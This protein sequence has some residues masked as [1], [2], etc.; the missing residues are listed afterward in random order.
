MRAVPFIVFMLLIG[1]LSATSMLCFE[2]QNVKIDKVCE[3]LED[4]FAIDIDK[5]AVSDVRILNDEC[6]FVLR[7][8][9]VDGGLK[10][11]GYFKNGELYWV[12]TYFNGDSLILRTDEIKSINNIEGF[13]RY[14][15][16]FIRR[17]KEFFNASPIF[18]DETVRAIDKLKVLND[19]QTIVEDNVLVEVYVSNLSVSIY[20]RLLVGNV[21]TPRLFGLWLPNPSRLFESGGNWA[22]IGF[23]DK[24]KFTKI[25]SYKIV[26][27]EE[28]AVNSTI[29]LMREYFS[30]HPEELCGRNLEDLVKDVESRMFYASREEGTLHPA[31]QICVY[32]KETLP[33]GIY[34]Y[35]ASFWADTGELRTSSVLGVYNKA[36]PAPNQSDLM[37]L[38]IAL[39]VIALTISAIYLLTARNR[40]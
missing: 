1:A 22:S 30:K 9:E 20:C 7:N 34:G 28:E 13:K 17:Y 27:T 36:S 23:Y 18:Y 16:N 40:T 4:V 10:V 3:F 39:T 33:N 37:T 14:I 31:W 2:F 8:D 6:S 38:G 11:Y 35:A 26:F 19:R 21:A 24:Y 32:F 5:Y 12:D 15:S 29:M 25:A